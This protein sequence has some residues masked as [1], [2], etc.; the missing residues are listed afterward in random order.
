MQPVC[1]L[2]MSG[3]QI[4]VLIRG[5][6]YSFLDKDREQTMTEEDY[7]ALIHYSS[8]SLQRQGMIGSAL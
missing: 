6:P 2:V 8:R 7:L 3:G 4:E 5:Q 1:E